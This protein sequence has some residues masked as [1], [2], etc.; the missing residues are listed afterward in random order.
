MEVLIKNYYESG[1][2]IL[3]CIGFATLLLHNNLIKKIIG[4]NIMDTAVFL[5][6]IAKGYIDGR[7][8]PIIIGKFK[9]VQGYINPIPTSLMLTGIVVAVSTTAFALALTIKLN[10]KYGTI[11]LDEIMKMEEE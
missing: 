8:A 5:F 7:E 2:V 4:M 9:G 3:F 10:E 6:F 11:E 1:A